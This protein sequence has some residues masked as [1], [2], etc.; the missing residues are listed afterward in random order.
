MR[1]PMAAAGTIATS[2][3]PGVAQLVIEVIEATAGRARTGPTGPTDTTGP[4]G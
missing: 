3:G 4:S 2:A 1:G